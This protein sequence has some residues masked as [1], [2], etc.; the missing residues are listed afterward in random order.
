MVC[1]TDL[2]RLLIM[3][4]CQSS[5]VLLFSKLMGQ[6]N[7][8]LTFLCTEGSGAGGCWVN[9]VLSVYVKAPVPSITDSK[10]K[11]PLVTSLWSFEWKLFL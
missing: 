4:L 8:K 9:T 1:R 2:C 6:K 11:H 7:R 3:L 5:I 10:A